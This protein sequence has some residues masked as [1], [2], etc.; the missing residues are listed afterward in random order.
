MG[1]RRMMES[2]QRAMGSLRFILDEDIKTVIREKKNILFRN[3]I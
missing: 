1:M 2:E 3:R